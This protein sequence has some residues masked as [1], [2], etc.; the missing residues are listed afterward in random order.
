MS[1]KTGQRERFHFLDG[2]RGFAVSMIIIYHSSSANAAAFFNSVKL[3]ILGRLYMV[4]T[5]SCVD[6]FFVLSGIVLL[7]PYLRRQ[8]EFKVVE[9]FKRRAQRL[10]PPYFFA[11]LFGA[12]VVWFNNVFPTWYNERGM[13]M[14]FSWL[15]TLKEAGIVSF[16]E[17]YYN[18]AWWS[19]GIEVAFY[20]A[21]PLIILLFPAQERLNNRRL[22]VII[23][24]T[25]I[26]SIALQQMFTLF[27]PN[28]YTAKSEF[29]YSLPIIRETIWRV[30]DYPLCF[31]MGVTLAARDFTKKEGWI[32]TSVGVGLIFAS[33]YYEVI[34]HSGAALLYGGLIA[35]AFNSVKFKKV[36]NSPVLIWLG[37]RSYSI[38]LTHLSVF[39]LVDNL[40]SRITP[41]RGMLYGVLTRSISIPL[42][43]LV[44][45][46][47]FEFVERRSAKGLVTGAATWP[48]QAKKY[49]PVTAEKPVPQLVEQVA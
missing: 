43:I 26:A 14:Q 17:G 30:I 34:V 20:L 15:E 18:L 23:F 49:M 24:S 40:V 7:R 35:V 33:W 19:L 11:L 27:F 3:P 9:Y 36:L 42:A 22:G 48:W 31:L 4:L 1:T 47:L 45:M 37:E 46:V 39:Y 6:L 25:L 5:S 12:L 41:G 8:R 2:V 10:Y 13:R 28:L 38:F 32:L 21:A 16:S 29:G 44:A